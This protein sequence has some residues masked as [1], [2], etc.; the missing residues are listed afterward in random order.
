M[1]DPDA[2]KKASGM[3]S[4]ERLLVVL[5]ALNI[6]NG[7]TVLELNR[8][9]GISRQAIYRILE[10][11]QNF[12]YV[13]RQDA[14]DR[15]HLTHLVR[16]LSAGFKDEEWITDIAAPVLERLVKEVVWP[17]ELA[18]FSDNAMYIRESTRWRSP[19]TI[20]R[21]TVGQRLP[22]VASASGRAYL[23]YCSENE[24]KTILDNLSAS[25]DPF[26]RLVHRKGYV[27]RALEETRS[28]GWATGDESFRLHPKTETL[29]VPILVAG[30]ARAVLPLT[31]IASAV[32]AEQIAERHLTQLQSAAREIGTKVQ[33]MQSRDDVAN[34]DAEITPLREAG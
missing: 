8:D 26:D 15:F 21:V 20:D 22:M 12:G 9:T 23:A 31:Y 28:R 34:M 3:R 27:E 33:M 1:D 16:R 11:L 6:R 17:T 14:T 2:K 4:A 24:R 7:A 29:A 5:R 13:R 19:F 10:T 30:E 25:E 32:T 18:V